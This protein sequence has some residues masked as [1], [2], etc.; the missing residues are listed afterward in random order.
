MPQLGDQAFGR[1]IGK[2]AKSRHIYTACPDCGA[3]RWVQFWT[4]L[5]TFG[6][7]VR[8]GNKKFR[9]GVPRLKYRGANS[10]RWKGGRVLAK[11][12]YIRVPI[13]PDNP[14]WPMA[15][16]GQ[17]T[18]KEHRLVMAQHLGRCLDRW[19]VVHHKNGD[20]SDNRIEN[21]E[22]LPEQMTHVTVTCLQQEVCELREQNKRLETRVTLLEAELALSSGRS[23]NA[24]V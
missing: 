17:R 19:E 20:R 21:L 14:Y 3:E 2:A 8:C 15:N 16:K 9:R 18:M 1:E 10:S 6:R 23:T 11:D 12:G 5:R 7:C 22:L 13:H 4:A 24:V